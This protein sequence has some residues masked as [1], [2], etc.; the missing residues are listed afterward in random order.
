MKLSPP[1]LRNL[2]LFWLSVFSLPV[3]QCQKESRGLR[4]K[5]K[6][7]VKGF[8]WRHSWFSLTSTIR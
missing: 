2:L 5:S 6:T 1:S 7:V 8:M 3:I 4:P